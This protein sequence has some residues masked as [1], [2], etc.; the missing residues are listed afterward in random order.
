MIDTTQYNEQDLAKIKQR[1]AETNETTFQ[2]VKA[3]VNDVKTRKDQALFEYTQRFDGFAID[4]SNIK[5]TPEETEEALK[6]VS[7]REIEII[8]RASQRIR[9][10]H[11]Q[12]KNNSWIDVKNQG[13]I[14][15]QLILPMEN[16]G[17]YVPGGKAAYPSTVLMNAVPAQIAGVSRIIMT[18]PANSE[19][20]INPY[21]LATASVLGITEIYK[22]G[23]AQAIAALA[24]GT[25]SV[26]KVDKIVGPGNIYVALAKQAVFG[27]VSIDSVAG[28]SEIT[29]IA[30]ETANPG[31][32]AADMLSQAEHDP[33]ASSILITPDKK[34]ALA[35]KQELIN[36]T[37]KLERKEII[38]QSLRNFGL[39]L[40]VNNIEEAV[41][42]ANKIAPEHLEICT[43][44]PF[45]LLPMIKNAGA[46]FL[47]HYTPEPLGDYMA[48]PNHVLP[49]SGTARFFSAL[50]LDDFVKKTSVISFNKQALQ[51]LAA[52]VIDFAN[53]E[54]LTAHANAVRIRTE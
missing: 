35:V 48:G 23:G 2:E 9:Q 7:A 18:T 37:A 25:E 10:F 12:Q 22:V 21:T 31:F 28:P 45:D 34:L 3:I 46:V 36:Q 19:G 15:G 39:I 27:Q 52:D 5:V 43:Q 17:L 16:V 50:G 11:E 54:G 33:Q 38:E 42:A 51:A 4:A 47:G 8:K 26:P 1:S 44:A 29:I 13:E 41:E 14:L 20:K 40:L 53:A 49:T 24:Y 32:V 30:D 6:Q